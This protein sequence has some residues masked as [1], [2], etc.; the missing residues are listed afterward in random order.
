M[1]SLKCRLDWDDLR[2][3][4]SYLIWPKFLRQMH[5]DCLV[6]QERAQLYR[7]W[8]NAL[9][10]VGL[11]EHKRLTLIRDRGR[12]TDSQHAQR[13][14]NAGKL[15]RWKIFPMRVKEHNKQASLSQICDLGWVWHVGLYV[16]MNHSRFFF[17]S[18]VSGVQKGNLVCMFR[19][20]SHM[21]GQL[22]L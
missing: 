8:N 7:H 9:W 3:C 21:I 4:G 10:V 6:K 11:T 16:L 19:L 1:K 14:N 20:W 5:R 18:S 22:L 13:S 2:S 15:E 17:Y 12:G